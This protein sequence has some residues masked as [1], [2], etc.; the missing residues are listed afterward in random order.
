[1]MTGVILAGGLNRRMGGRSKALLP[2]QDQP[3]LLRQLTEMSRICNQMIVVSNEPEAFQLLLATNSIPMNVQWVSDI[4][5][6]KGPLSGIH[7]AAQAVTEEFMWIVGCDMPF[8]SSEAAEA[9]RQ[10]CQEA[11]VDAVIPVIDGKVHPLHGIYSRLVG[12]EAEVLL[13]QE[14]YRL[15]GLLD[16]IDWL[17]A[18]NAFFEK[19]NLPSKFVT[20]V[21][22]PD[23]Y[24][25]M[26]ENLS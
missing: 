10:L 23:E 13:K 7:A 9:M 20:N 16:H 19:L 25:F 8:I 14:Q 22:T 6:Q 15:M 21:N 5:I 24:K 12:S 3:L 1:M 4:Y 11:N 18:E 2:V 17:P 26:L